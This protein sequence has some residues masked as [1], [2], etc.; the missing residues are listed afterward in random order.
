MAELEEQLRSAESACNIFVSQ[1]H[2]LIDRI[3][4]ILGHPPDSINPTSAL[5]ELIEYYAEKENK[6][7]R[8]VWAAMF[9]CLDNMTLLKSGNCIMRAD[10]CAEMRTICQQLYKEIDWKDR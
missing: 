2:L 8:S 10:H 7:K 3:S 4:E 5:S 1:Q 9:E 6:L